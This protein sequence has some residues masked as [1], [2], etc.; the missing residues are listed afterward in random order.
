[1]RPFLPERTAHPRSN[2]R[3]IAENKDHLID[4]RI[5]DAYEPVK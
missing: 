2:M 5:V 3:I 1:M 4:K